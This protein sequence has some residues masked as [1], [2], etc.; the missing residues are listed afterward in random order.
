MGTFI[1]LGVEKDISAA[2]IF[3]R[4]VAEWGTSPMKTCMLTVLVL[5]M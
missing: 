2:M 3:T 5:A 1:L 4:E